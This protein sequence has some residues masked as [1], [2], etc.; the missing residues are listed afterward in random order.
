M[1]LSDTDVSG[2]VFRILADYG[3]HNFDVD[4]LRSNAA[5]VYLSADL[6][7]DSLDHVECVIDLEDALGVVIDDDAWAGVETVAEVIEL[8][9]RLVRE[10]GGAA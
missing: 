2:I 9:Q 4:E 5:S 8:C 10:H 6:S 7:F 1:A 3:G